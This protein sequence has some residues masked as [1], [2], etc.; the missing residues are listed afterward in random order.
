MEGHGRDLEEQFGRR[1]DVKEQG[2]L[3]FELWE[4]ETEAYHE[5]Y[6]AASNR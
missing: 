6:L 1:S 3:G 5:E 2:P 4:M